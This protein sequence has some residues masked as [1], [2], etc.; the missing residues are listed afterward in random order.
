MIAPGGMVGNMG[1]PYTTL[2]GAVDVHVRDLHNVVVN[3]Y[4]H[5][6]GATTTLSV[7]ANIGDISIDVVSAVG[8][9]IG[10]FVH[11]GVNTNT[12][13][14]IH[15]QI[16]DILGTVIT[17][18]RPIDNN[19]LIGDAVTVSIIDLNTTIGSLA[20]P[21]SYKYLP[22]INRVEHIHRIMISMIH[23]TSADDSTFG[24]I[25]ALTNGVVFRAQVNGVTGTFTNWKSN[26]DFILDFFDVVYTDKAGAGSFGTRGRGS[27]SEIDIAIKLDGST[28]D[29]LEVLI[30]DDLTA[31]TSFRIKTQGHVEGV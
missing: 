12:I 15:P 2:D 19:F 28:G 20:A 30:Q 9:T 29:F 25:T 3:D 17:L 16:T 5:A 13:E 6:H 23:A 21:I 4:V 27:F 11:L 8:F 31:L 10:Q 22:G 26:R 18:D 7:A 14:P 1:G 24:N